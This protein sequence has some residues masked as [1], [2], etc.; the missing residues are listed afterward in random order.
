MMYLLYYDHVGR[1]SDLVSLKPQ[2]VYG[3][4]NYV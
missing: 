3:I 2:E 4:C 1:S